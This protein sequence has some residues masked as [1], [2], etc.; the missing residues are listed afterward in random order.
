[1]FLQSRATFS[2]FGRPRNPGVGKQAKTAYFGAGVVSLTCFWAPL[3]HPPG[4]CKENLC[5]HGPAFCL[6]GAAFCLHGAPEAQ[7]LAKK[8]LNL[9]P[10]LSEEAA[11][12]DKLGPGP[13]PAHFTLTL[14]KMLRGPF[15]GQSDD[16]SGSQNGTKGSHRPP[17]PPHDPQDNQ[18]CHPET[19]YPHQMVKKATLRLE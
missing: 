9:A 10:K 16:Y 1:M 7:K 13:G 5:L 18:K 19:D 17:P 4:P 15:S 14:N 12:R 2:V 6:H 8:R 11:R 3:G